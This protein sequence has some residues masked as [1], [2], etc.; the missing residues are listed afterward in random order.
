[1]PT[2]DYRC[3]TCG[4]FEV[5]QLITENPL[6]ACPNCGGPVKRLMSRNVCIVYKGSGWHCTDYS[7]HGYNGAPK[8]DDSQAEASAAS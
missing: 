6:A 3:E 7:K 4:V 1:M 8:T 2:Y 5:K